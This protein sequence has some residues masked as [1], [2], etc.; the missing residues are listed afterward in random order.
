MYVR[1]IYVCT[2]G[3][4]LTEY[5][6]CEKGSHFIELYNLMDNWNKADKIIKEPKEI[7]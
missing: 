3:K 6:F 7:H 4:I 1:N 5:L 2:V